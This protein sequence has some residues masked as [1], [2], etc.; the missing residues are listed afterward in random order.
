MRSSFR[1]RIT[2]AFTLLSAVVGGALATVV[3]V[4]VENYENETYPARMAADF[5]WL[6]DMVQSGRPVLLSPG[7]EHWVGAEVPPAFS[8]LESGYHSIETPDSS[9]HVMVGDIAGERHVLAYDDS[10]FEG[11]E[12]EMTLWLGVG[13]AASIGVALWLA[14]LTSN[15]VIQPVRDL[16][17]AVREER[18]PNELPMLQAEDEVGELARA[19]ATRAEALQELLKREQLF[20]ADVSHELRTPLT[21]ILGAAE[22]LKLR[23]GQSR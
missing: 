20:T 11:L 10:Q 19:F 3:Y 14:T 23:A 22:V 4:A 8:G 1:R 5:A 6:T 9:H 21:V 17:Q 18:A 7:R 15:R 12:D 2:I 13:W 16:A